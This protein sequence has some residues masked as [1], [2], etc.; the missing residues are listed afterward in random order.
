DSIFHGGSKENFDGDAE[1]GSVTNLT[2]QRLDVYNSVALAL[3]RRPGPLG[4]SGEIAVAGNGNS[5]AYDGDGVLHI[6]YYDS[7][8]KTLKYVTRGTDNGV[9]SPMRIDA[10][11]DDVGGYVSIALDQHS[12]PSVAYFDGSAGDLRFAHFDGQHWN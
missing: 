1:F 10:S 8:A 11:S 9:S 12:R 2:F 4:A 5:I 6:A 3:A 7:I